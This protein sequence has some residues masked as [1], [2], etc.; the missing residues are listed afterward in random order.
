MFIDDKASGE[1]QPTPTVRGF[2]D[3]ASKQPALK[4]YSYFNERVCAC[5]QY[6]NEIGDQGAWLRRSEDRRSPWHRLDG[7][8]FEKPRTFGAL[9]R[10]LEAL[11]DECKELS[12]VA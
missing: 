4:E 11:R 8:A 5:S 6:A 2:L 7:A 10:R 1:S 9:A 12:A 3:F